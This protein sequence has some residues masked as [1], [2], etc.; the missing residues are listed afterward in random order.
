MRLNK[1]HKFEIL[2]KSKEIYNIIY[3]K[4]LA[5]RKYTIRT[6]IRN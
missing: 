1:V 6:K 5:Y 2:K 3:L 4:G